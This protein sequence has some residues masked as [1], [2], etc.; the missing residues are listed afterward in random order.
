MVKCSR[1]EQDTQPFKVNIHS[2][3]VRTRYFYLPLVVFNAIVDVYCGSSRSLDTHRD[4]WVPCRSLRRRRRR[5]AN[6]C[7]PTSQPNKLLQKLP[8]QK[9]SRARVSTLATM[10]WMWNLTRNQS[11]RHAMPSLK[12]TWRSLVGTTDTPFSSQIHHCATSRTK[13]TTKSYSKTSN[14]KKNRLSAL[15]SVL[16]TRD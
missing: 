4:H 14:T 1:Y 11:W 2:N 5:Y 7:R 16:M 3:V 15:S 10:M 13:P 6:W 12:R 9:H 8:S